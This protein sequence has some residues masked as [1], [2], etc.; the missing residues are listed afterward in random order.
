M[1]FGEASHVHW[2]TNLCKT[3]DVPIVSSPVGTIK[4]EN[5]MD[6]SDHY[7]TYNEGNDQPSP[8]SQAGI[9]L[10]AASKSYHA[11]SKPVK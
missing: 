11:T 5:S 7:Y 4:Y 2:L 9:I 8:D 10:K 6:S 1:Y 3:L